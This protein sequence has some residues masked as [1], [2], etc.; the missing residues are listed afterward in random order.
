MTSDAVQITRDA[1]AAFMSGDL[2]GL[3]EYFTDDVEWV[4]PDSLP[5][6]GTVQGRQAVIDNFAAIPQVWSEFSV[7]PDE[8][9]DAGNHV[10][11]RGVQHVA[12]TGGSTESRYLHLVTLRGGKIVRGE[13]IADTAKGLQ[14]LG[15]GAGA[16]AQPA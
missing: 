16:N 13:Y 8:Y 14:A 15:Q 1:Y 12:G 7:Q 2:R 11:V 6:G 3:S 10:L 9:I 5:L 4:T